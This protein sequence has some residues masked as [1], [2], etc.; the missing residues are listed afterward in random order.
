VIVVP[1]PIGVDGAPDGTLTILGASDAAPLFAVDAGLSLGLKDLR[2]TPHYRDQ[3]LPEAGKIMKETITVTG[4]LSRDVVKRVVG[5]K[6]G[7]LF[8]CLARPGASARV[9]F[10]IDAAGR[11]TS[12]EPGE[13]ALP[14]ARACLEKTLKPLQFPPPEGGVALVT[15]SVQ[16]D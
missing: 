15:Y 4:K 8:G 6:W 2:G 16:G 7:L 3:P 1:D 12:V 5:D 10:V 9:R 14:G 11:V 13:G